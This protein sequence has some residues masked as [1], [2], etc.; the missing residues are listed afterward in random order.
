MPRFFRTLAVATAFC[1]LC[2][3]NLAAQT[4]KSN[5]VSFKFDGGVALQ[6]SS[7]LTDTEGS[8]SVNRW[9]G[10]LGVTYAWNKRNSIGLS[11]GGGSSKYDFG[12][13]TAFGGDA[14]WEEIEDSRITLTGRFGF[15][16]NGTIFIVPS[17]RYNGEKDADTSEGRTFG[18][19]AAAAWWLSKDLTIGPGIGVF[20]KLGNG[21]RVFPVLVIDWNITERWNL[22]T[23]SGLASSQGA[24][25]TLSY[26]LSETWRFGLTSRYEKVEFRLDENG[27]T[28][29]GIGRDESIP[30]ILSAIWKPNKSV[31]LSLFAGLALA[32]K[33]KLKDPSGETL[34]E[35]GYDPAAVYGG[36]FELKF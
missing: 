25:L 10:S 1:S 27:T 12:E 5:P 15:G 23:G 28:P 8:F 21:T 22:A 16:R 29:D 35:T 32:G 3:G 17:A 9:F 6:S 30:V 18:V 11:A 14:P 36:T 31:K 26:K 13:Q 33:L 19:F 4:A 20:S 34:S 7:D 2:A 24:G